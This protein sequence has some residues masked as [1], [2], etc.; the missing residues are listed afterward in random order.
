M[1]E[2]AGVGVDGVHR[3]RILAGVP[4]ICEARIPRRTLHADTGHVCACDRSRRV[5]QRA[6][7]H[8]PMRLDG[9]VHRVVSPG[10]ERGGERECPVSRDRQRRAAVQAQREPR[11]GDSGNGAADREGRRW[12]WRRWRD[13]RASSAATSASAAQHEYGERQ[14]MECACHAQDLRGSSVGAAAGCGEPSS[15]TSSSAEIR[16]RPAPRP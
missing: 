4:H 10:G 9:D 5:R 15:T 1:P 14:E 13:V 8:R 3:H 7:L 16:I 6:G 11:T 12:R 2:P